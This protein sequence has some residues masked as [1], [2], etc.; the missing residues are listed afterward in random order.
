MNARVRQLM[1]A[2]LAAASLLLLSIVLAIGPDGVDPSLGT[3]VRTFAL[4]V[5]A[6]FASFALNV[7]FAAQANGREGA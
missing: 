4:L 7:L 5:I 3:R 6:A 2:G 1:H